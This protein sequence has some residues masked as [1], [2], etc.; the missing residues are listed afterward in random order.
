[1]AESSTS[2]RQDES[3]QRLDAG[4][5]STTGMFHS[6]AATQSHQLD[7]FIDLEVKDEQGQTMLLRSLSSEDHHLNTIVARRLLELGANSQAVDRRGRGD[8]SSDLP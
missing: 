4:S 1:M 2:A 3:V 6:L 8:F 7:H 5:T